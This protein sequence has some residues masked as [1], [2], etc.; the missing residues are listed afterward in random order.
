MAMNG[1]RTDSVLDALERDIAL[2]AEFSTTLTEISTENEV[3]ACLAQGLRQLVGD[4]TVILVSNYAP[5]STSFDVLA[6]SGLGADVNAL[7]AMIGKAPVELSNDFPVSDKQVMATGH[8]TKLEGGVVELARNVLSPLI[9]QQ[10]VTLLGSKEVYIVGYATNGCAGGVCMIS[11]QSGLTLHRAAIEALTRIATGVIKRL[12]AEQAIARTEAETDKLK[13]LLTK[14]PHDATEHPFDLAASH[15]NENLYRNLVNHLPQ[16]IFLKDRSSNYLSCNLNYAQDLGVLPEDIAGKDDFAFHPRE[17]AELYRADDLYVMGSG[18]PKEVEEQYQ[19]GGQQRWIHTIKVPYHDEHGGVIGVLGIF[20]DITERKRNEETLVY[21]MKAV[22]STSEAIAVSDARGR[23]FYQNRAFTELFG[24]ASAGELAAVGGIHAVSKDPQVTRRRL[25]ALTQGKSWAGELEMV[26]KSGRVFQAYN[27]A[28]AIKD[29][30]GDGIG[31]IGIITDITE[32][33]HAEATLRLFKDLVQHSSDAVGMSTP[34]GKHYFQNAAFDCMFGDVGRRPNQTLYVDKRIGEQVFDTIMHGGRWQGEVEMFK[35]DGSI[36]NIFLRAFAI[37]DENERIVGLVGLHTDITERKQAEAERVKLETQLLQ[38]QKMESVGRLAGGVAHDF[39]NMLG[40]ILG[41]AEMALEELE[42]SGPLRSTLEEI[43][44]AAQRSTELTRNLLAFARKQTIAPKILDINNIIKSTINMLHRLIGEDIELDWRPQPNLWSVRMDPSQ[45]DQ[46]MTNLCVNARDAISG[47]GKVTIET[48]NYRF[49]E[50]YCT[51]HAETVPGDYVLLTVSDDG[52]GMNKD[53]LQ[54]LFEPFFTTKPIGKG[55]GLG[56]ATVYGIV[57]QNNG[58]INAYSEPGYGTVFRIYLPRYVAEF[59]EVKSP[60]LNGTLAHGQETILVVEDEPA[61]LTL[62]TA[63]LRH[64]GYTV[65]AAVTPSEARRLASEHT[66][67]IHLL[68]TDVVM[69][70]MNGRALARNL[71][72]LRPHLKCLFMSGYTADII[73][74][75]GVLDSG[76]H[77]LQKPFN[78]S[79]LATKVRQVLDGE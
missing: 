23:H 50:D 79:N 32:R 66:G 10:V 74:H 28:D 51:T 33:K 5:A 42:P 3:Y 57:R 17:L 54:H 7:T 40:V 62:T 52:C 43:I 48:S 1:D 58:V 75:R 37:K 60:E 12:R 25:E 47:V 29:S 4:G 65:I 18:Q 59:D 69:P 39:N 35:Q 9:S 70:E 36:L 53:T 30:N 6:S 22:E 73:A 34:D 72:S 41:H 68:L 67:E 20:D 19:V 14:R 2:V 31:L 49:N 44:T 64:L 56:M 8:L 78:R 55:T 77:F 38:S 46:L 11:R 71:Q 13:E 16:R 76:V 15:H 27:H 45:V 63:M 61:I 26:T 24:Y 21:V